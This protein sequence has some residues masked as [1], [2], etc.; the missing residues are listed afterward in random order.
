MDVDREMSVGEWKRLIEEFSAAGVKQFTF[1]GGEALLKEGCQELLAFAAKRALVGLLSNGRLVT[2]EVIRFCAEHGIRLSV[3][4]PGMNS[5]S[6]NTG[7][8]T[9]VEH[10]LGIFARAKKLGCT[11]T[12]GIAV[13]KLNLPE[14]Y[15]TISA[16]LIAGADTLLMNRFLPGG[17]GLSSPELL[18]TVDDVRHAADVAEEVLSRAKRHGTFGTEMP[19]CLIDRTKYH[20]LNATT[21]CSAATSFFV[22]GPNGKIRVCNHSPVE[23]VHWSEWR[24]LPGSEEW[25]HYV[26]HDYLPEDCDNCEQASEC[27][28]G[29]REAARVF[30]GTPRDPDPLFAIPN[31]Q[32]K[33]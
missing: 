8:D 29:C 21:G 16:A 26:R 25:M 22:V 5:Y 13:T 23:L 11:T 28:G 7:S 27:L 2:D 33:R 1:T 12:V 10:I 3:S 9:P 32:G 15:E 30:F 18:L 4:M 17:R 31:V 24:S 14:L 20:Y 6:V 19:A